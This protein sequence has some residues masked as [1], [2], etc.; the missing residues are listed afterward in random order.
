MSPKL[1]PVTSITFLD[2]DF[3]HL[4]NNI[5]QESTIDVSGGVILNFHVSEQSK[6]HPVEISIDRRG[7]LRYFILFANSGIPPTAELVWNFSENRFSQFGEG[8]NHLETGRALFQLYC[9]NL[10]SLANC[11]VHEVS[12]TPMHPHKAIQQHP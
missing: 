3:V 2:P 4:I 6:N 10:A 9:R 8:G 1:N 7:N 11:G 5:L 12:I